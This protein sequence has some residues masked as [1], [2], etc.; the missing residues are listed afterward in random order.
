VN[1][2]RALPLAEKVLKLSYAIELAYSD[3]AR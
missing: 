1:V 2:W 3:P